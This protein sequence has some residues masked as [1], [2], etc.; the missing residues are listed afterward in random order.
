MAVWISAAEETARMEASAEEARIVDTRCGGGGGITHSTIIYGD[1]SLQC[2]LIIVVNKL[3]DMTVFAF[4]FC[5]PPKQKR[6]DISI[7]HLLHPSPGRPRSNTC[8]T[9]KEWSATTPARE[10]YP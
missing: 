8:C 3:L 1:D 10:G 2:R 5:F 6:R 4:I 7:S 9:A